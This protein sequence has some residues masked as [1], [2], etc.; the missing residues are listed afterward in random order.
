MSPTSV[1]ATMG[2]AAVAGLSAMVAM[3]YTQTYSQ[4]YNTCINHD[5]CKKILG[6]IQDTDYVYRVDKDSV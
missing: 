4:S 1:A 2:V 5:K 6:D 3:M